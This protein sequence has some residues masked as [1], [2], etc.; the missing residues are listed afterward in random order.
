MH[1]FYILVIFSSVVILLLSLFSNRFNQSEIY[2]AV[3]AFFFILCLLKPIGISPDDDNYIEILRSLNNDIQLDRTGIGYSRDLIWTMLVYILSA[4]T[5]DF[6]GVKI[7]AGLSFLIKAYIIKK[8]CKFYMFGLGV[9]ISTF[10]ILHETIQ[11]RV[12]FVTSL[13]FIIIFIYKKPISRF[14]VLMISVLGHLQAAILILPII[15]NKF[16]AKKFFKFIIIFLMI[17]PNIVYFFEINKYLTNYIENTNIIEISI[18]IG[19]HLDQTE[20]RDINSFSYI[21]LGII[22]LI[23]RK[24]SVSDQNNILISFII[25]SF[26]CYGFLYGIPDL[27]WRLADYLIAPISIYSGNLKNILTRILL[28]LY[29]LMSITKLYLLLL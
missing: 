4:G 24:E 6:I 9:Y 7:L 16:L 10:Y 5:W 25:A 13:L 21:L 14:I 3:V 22:L 12:S 23:A 11:Y 8:I 29:A 17:F 19:R 15:I 28:S 18:Y 2:I 1:E 27:R 26:L 20:G